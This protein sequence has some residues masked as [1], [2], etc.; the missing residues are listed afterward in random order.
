MIPLHDSAQ[1]VARFFALAWHHDG[2][3]PYIYRPPANTVMRPL[4]MGN[5]SIIAFMGA[6][7]IACSRSLF[8]LQGLNHF[9][10]PS[11]V[12]LNR[13]AAT[14]W[15]ARAQ[16]SKKLIMLV[17]LARKLARCLMAACRSDRKCLLKMLILRVCGRTVE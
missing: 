10:A 9:F 17:V 12:L 8:S 11:N 5:Y 7:I 13:A 2:F 6:M 14:L 15:I 3:A 16:S 4:P 1:T